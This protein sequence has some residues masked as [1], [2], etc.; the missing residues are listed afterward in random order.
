MRFAA[1]AALALLI[2]LPA[3]AAGKR[4]VV[5]FVADGLRYSSVTPETA[6][7]MARLRKEGVDFA[8]SHSIYP[9]QTTANASAIATGH[10]LGDTGNYAN[11]LYFGFP[12][13]CKQNITVAFLEDDCILRDIKGHFPDDYIA[14]TTLIE[15][16][17]NAGLNTVVIGKKGP[18]GVQFLAS[19]DSTN[20]DVGGPLGIFIDEATGHP[21]NADGSP[22]KSTMLGTDLA[23]SIAKVAGGGPAE[24]APGVP[25]LVQQA[26]QRQAVTQVLIPR[27]KKA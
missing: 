23:T 2:A 17:H 4:N 20:D 25:N 26:W 27:L 8:N 3:Q 6:P 24:P 13:P 18:A 9:T 22:T 12:V 15:A 7:T 1:A 21:T 11:S 14:Q 16:A 10:Y 19:L 5:V